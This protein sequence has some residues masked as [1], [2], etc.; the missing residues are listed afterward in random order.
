LG[1]AAVEFTVSELLVMRS[2]L[3]PGGSR[4]TTLARC[5]LSETH[6]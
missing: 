1:F 4:Y 5:P 3:G 2:E 6:G